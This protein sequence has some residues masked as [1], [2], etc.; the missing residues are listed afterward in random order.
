M[1]LQCTGIH[2]ES[3]LSLVWTL[4]I[5]LFLHVLGLCSCSCSGLLKSH[6]PSEQELLHCLFSTLLLT[7]QLFGFDIGIQTWAVA[8]IF[9]I[10][11]MKM[12]LLNVLMLL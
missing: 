10:S 6:F 8:V 2:E 5:H 7:C 1:C 3:L 12:H 9:F 4:D 11:L